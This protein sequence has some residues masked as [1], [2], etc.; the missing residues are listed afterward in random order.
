MKTVLHVLP[1]SIGVLHSS[2]ALARHALKIYMCMHWNTCRSYPVPGSRAPSSRPQSAGPA[3]NN[4]WQSPAADPY[5][6]DPAYASTGSYWS[7]NA[8]PCQTSSRA[9]NSRARPGTCMRV[10]VVCVWWFGVRT[11]MPSI[12]ACACVHQHVHV[13][14]WVHD[15]RHVWLPANP[16]CWLALFKITTHAQGVECKPDINCALPF[17]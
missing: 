7:P 10:Y 17:T 6:H 13:N 12:H 4:I 15:V 2:L 1:L 5:A 16:K 9:T 3:R 11:S 14:K 8:Q